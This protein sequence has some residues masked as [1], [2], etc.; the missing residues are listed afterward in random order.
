MPENP[1][2]TPT[3]PA[4]GEFSFV[5]P[6]SERPRLKR[7][8]LKAPSAP[9]SSPGERPPP[10]E[11]LPDSPRPDPA[12]SIRASSSGPA[13]RPAAFRP[14][15][16]S[17]IPAQAP[18][19]GLYYSTG[20]RQ[21]KENP[22]PMKT[23]HPTASTATAAAMS[24]SPRTVGSAS[25]PGRAASV[26]DYRANIDRQ[27][28]EQKSVGGVLG[29]IVYVLIGFFVLSA[30]LAGYGAYTL[31][32][33]IHAQSVTVNDLD[34][35]YSAEN[36]TLTGDLATTDANLA[37][38]QAQL[39]REQEVIL[40]QQDTINKLVIA[41]DN[42]VAALRAERQTRA[43]ETAALKARVKTLENTPRLGQ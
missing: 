24:S 43:A 36:K 9:A 18:S 17:S 10:A 22:P 14:P 38:T 11:P 21:E 31:S 41:N 16:T 3:P 12:P 27:A 39:R 25:A 2:P 29:I 23:I 32:R 6:G 5:D 34:T 35:R 4:S 13:P 20:A 33:Q 19:S 42:T 28:R 1:R 37:D 30:C 15:G 26:S 8:N 7:R 40:R